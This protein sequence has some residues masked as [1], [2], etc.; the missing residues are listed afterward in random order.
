M[1][2]EQRLERSLQI[3]LSKLHANLMQYKALPNDAS[4]KV[5]DATRK[6]QGIHGNIM[7]RINWLRCEL[8]SLS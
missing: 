3:S 8:D 1:T 6:F 7:G 4:L 5:L 2:R